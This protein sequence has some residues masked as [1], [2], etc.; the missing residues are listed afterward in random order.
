MKKIYLLALTTLFSV[1]AFAQNQNN[2]LTLSPSKNSQTSAQLVVTPGVED[3]NQK[4]VVDIYSYNNNIFIN[5]INFNNIEGTVSVY[6]LGGKLI[7]SQN[8]N[9]ALLQLELPRTGIY[10]VTVNANGNI[11]TERVFLK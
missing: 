4:Q 6:D 10:I 9:N 11:F 5:P 1:G 7:Q 2:E 3:I 8:L